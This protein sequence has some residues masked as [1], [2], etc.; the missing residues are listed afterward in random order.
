MTKVAE[1]DKVKLPTKKDLNK[2]VE[3]MTKLSTAIITE[4]WLARICS[5]ENCRL[6]RFAE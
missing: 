1:H 5:P 6:K 2:K 4:V 3:E